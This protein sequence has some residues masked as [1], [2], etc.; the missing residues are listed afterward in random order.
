MPVPGVATPD[1]HALR[2]HA[3]AHR[4]HHHHHQERHSHGTAHDSDEEQAVQS[5]PPAVDQLG[6]PRPSPRRAQR[7][8]AGDEDREQ[9]QRSQAPGQGRRSKSPGGIRTREGAVS[10]RMQSR[11]HRDRKVDSWLQASAAH[12]A[13]DASWLRHATSGGDFYPHGGAMSPR[14]WP[15]PPPRYNAGAEPLL[16]RSVMSP[17]VMP[18][19]ILSPQMRG[20]AGREACA[21]HPAVDQLQHAST[22]LPNQ[23]YRTQQNAQ[24]LAALLARELATLQN[25][26]E[27]QK[28]QQQES[29]KREQFLV[30]AL[31][32]QFEV[33]SKRICDLRTES[34]QPFATR[35]FTSP[36]MP[37]PDPDS[38]RHEDIVGLEIFTSVLNRAGAE[39][40]KSEA[41]RGEA[42]PAFQVSPPSPAGVLATLVSTGPG[43]PHV[44]ESM[45]QGGPCHASGLVELGDALLEV[46]G[47]DVRTSLLSDIQ[48]KIIGLPGSTVRLL[49]QRGS[50]SPPVEVAL[51]R[52]VP[53]RC[54]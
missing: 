25:L 45:V 38:D 42:S 39:N 31:Q 40:M 48:S 41:L 54:L 20:T 24:H 2:G 50:Q 34:P 35:T 30:D 17:R 28:R 52:S 5:S 6:G 47:V 22:V 19:H 51:T 13:S 23:L 1:P 9:G 7:P 16:D 4:H 46:D 21:M 3:H 10:P 33:M 49:L 27:Q 18:M 44:I 11:T 29:Q 14:A 43:R 8:A 15:A 12:E 53:P 32:Q 26:S 36:Q 37:C